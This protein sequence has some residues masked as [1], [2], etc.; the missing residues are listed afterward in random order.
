MKKELIFIS[1]YL[2]GQ[3]IHGQNQEQ[4]VSSS[5][6]NGQNGDTSIEW[7]LGETMINSFSAGNILLTQ[8]FHQPSLKVTAIKT[9]DGIPFTVETYPNPTN[10]LL[11]IQLENAAMQN[12]HYELYDMNGKV[13]EQD[14]LDSNITAI[15]MVNYPV[16]V[17]LL[18]VMQLNKEIKTFEIVKN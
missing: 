15:N 14:E 11:L 3:L 16:G 6:G 13:L 10:E 8:G 12:F 4:V 18:K 2:I 9:L 7:T 1:L 5:G 17:Y